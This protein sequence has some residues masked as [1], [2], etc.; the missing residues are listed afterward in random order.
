MSEI[1]LLAIEITPYRETFPQAIP[2]SYVFTA[3]AKI[4]GQVKRMQYLI[5]KGD[6]VAHFNQTFNVCRESLKDLIEDLREEN[7]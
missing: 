5:D 7:E 4:D 1:E 6:L 3:T 2:N